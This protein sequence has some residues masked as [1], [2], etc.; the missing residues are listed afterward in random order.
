MGWAA[1]QRRLPLATSQRWTGPRL[2]ATS[3]VP[4]GLYLTSV[5]SLPVR[6]IELGVP[7]G[8]SQSCTTPS[9]WPAASCLPFGASATPK[10]GAVASMMRSVRPLATSQSITLRSRPPE[11]SFTLSRLKESP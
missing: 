10:M 11:A 6:S 9:A 5:V 4:S 7:E 8:S 3:S 1:F 2:P